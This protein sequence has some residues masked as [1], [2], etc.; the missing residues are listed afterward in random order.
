M[1]PKDLKVDQVISTLVP[2][3]AGSSS[4]DKT[5]RENENGWQVSP[6]SFDK[7]FKAWDDHREGPEHCKAL[8][9]S[10]IGVGIGFCT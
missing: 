8:A 2:V 10:E 4:L 7:W 5:F 9:G 1:K 6:T 3:G